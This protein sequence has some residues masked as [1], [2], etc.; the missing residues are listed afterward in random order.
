MMAEHIHHLIV[1]N[2]RAAPIGVVSTL[3]VISALIAICDEQNAL[4]VDRR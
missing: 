2:E 1:L 4:M 3:D